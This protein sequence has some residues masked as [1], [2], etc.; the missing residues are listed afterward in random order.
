MSRQFFIF[1]IIL[2]VLAG[3]LV[4][5]GATLRDRDE[6]LRGYVDATQDSNLPYRIPRLG[7]NAELTQYSPDQ[8]PR[9]LDMMRAAHITWVRQFFRWD[10]IEP[11]RGIYQ[12]DQS[13]EIVKPFTTDSDLKL[14]AVLIDSPSW[15]RDPKASVTAP[16]TDPASFATFAH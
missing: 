8:L 15:A 1:I 14:V 12:W 13:D 9:Q 16:P 6:T 2:A 11:Q 10:Q 5:A 7:V 3:S 4:T